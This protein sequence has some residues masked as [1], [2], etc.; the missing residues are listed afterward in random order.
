V[1]V[2][3]LLERNAPWYISRLLPAILACSAAGCL[4][5]ASPPLHAHVTGGG[6]LGPLTPPPHIEYPQRVL[7]TDDRSVMQMR[8]NLA[9][10]GVFSK[11]LLRRFDIT[12]GYLADLHFSSDQEDYLRHGPN[13]QV[14]YYPFVQRLRFGDGLSKSAIRVGVS[15]AGEV[16]FGETFPASGQGG[17]GTASVSF[18][19]F[20]FDHGSAGI[21]GG[22]AVFAY[23]ETGVG[24]VVNGSY[25]YFNLRHYGLITAGLVFRLPAA[26]GFVPLF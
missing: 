23:G 16:L 21:G 5:F 12:A 19:L 11:Q 6:A 25:R 9:P 15:I 4:P 7:H 10:L 24:L 26:V 20:T 17:G 13:L 18:D 2:S 22:G 14:T 1:R 3:E 8:F